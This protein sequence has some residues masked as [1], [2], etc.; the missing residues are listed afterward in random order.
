MDPGILERAAPGVALEAA[1]DRR[2][3]AVLGVGRGG[4]DESESERENEKEW[5]AASGH[6]DQR[7]PPGGSGRCARAQALPPRRAGA[8][9]GSVGNARLLKGLGRASARMCDGASGGRGLDSCA[10]ARLPDRAPGPVS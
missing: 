10:L 2:L 4:G 1:L 5:S 9:S 8:A 7:S 6:E 3:A